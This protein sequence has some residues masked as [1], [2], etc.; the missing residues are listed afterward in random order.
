M[1]QLMTER[2]V[3]GWSAREVSKALARGVPEHMLVGEDRVPNATYLTRLSAGT[4]VYTSPADSRVLAE[5]H[6]EESAAWALSVHEEDAPRFIDEALAAAFDQWHQYHHGDRVVDVAVGEERARLFF[7]L[8]GRRVFLKT[9]DGGRLLSP[10]ERPI[11]CEVLEDHGYTVSADQE[12]YSFGDWRVAEFRRRL[13][14]YQ[15]DDERV[16]EIVAE[17][18]FGH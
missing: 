1:G 12:P 9:W 18:G 15:P 2:F 4:F 3:L 16:A 5:F 17:I 10:N 8:E 6:N 14:M 7:C 11:T 13:A